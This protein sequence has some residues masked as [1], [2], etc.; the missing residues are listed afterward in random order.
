MLVMTRGVNDRVAVDTGF[1]KHVT[2]S[3]VRFT[4]RDWGEICDEDRNANEWAATNGAR[5]LA[6]YG[7]GDDRVWIIREA[8]GSATTVLF[9]SEY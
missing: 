6:S 8:D 4:R 3:I 7:E 9:P 1:G 2:K 5:I